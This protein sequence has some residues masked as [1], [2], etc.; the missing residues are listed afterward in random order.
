MTTLEKWREDVIQFLSNHKKYRV[1]GRELGPRLLDELSCNY[2][3]TERGMVFT[4]LIAFSAGIISLITTRKIGFSAAVTSSLVL[5]GIVMTIAV[6][7]KMTKRKGEEISEEECVD[8]LIRLEQMP[9]HWWWPWSGTIRDVKPV[10][11]FY[12]EVLKHL[13]NYQKFGGKMLPGFDI[14]NCFN[15]TK[16]GV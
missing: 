3:Y 2:G 12:V 7:C 10:N 1:L 5:F 8:L 16:Q 9:Q 11:E 4:P 13:Y 14:V 6:D 15:A